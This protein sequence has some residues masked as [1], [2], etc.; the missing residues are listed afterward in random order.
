MYSKRFPE[1]ESLIHTPMEYIKT[2]QVMYKIF[3]KPFSLRTDDQN[4]CLHVFEG[5]SIGQNNAE[6]S[7]SS[8]CIYSK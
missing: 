3:S 7:Y 4:V 1:L 8:V 5:Y 6:V 2:V